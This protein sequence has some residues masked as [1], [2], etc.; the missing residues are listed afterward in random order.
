MSNNASMSDNSMNLIVEYSSGG[1]LET[2]K[3]EGCDAWMGAYADWSE[4][5]GLKLFVEGV[6]KDE[7]GWSW[8]WDCTD[9]K[10]DC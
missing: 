9:D 3:V 5:L 6:G 8:G 2:D 4:E 1:V 10:L 7:V